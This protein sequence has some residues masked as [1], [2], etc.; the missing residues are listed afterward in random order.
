MFTNQLNDHRSSTS[1]RP[2]RPLLYLQLPNSYPQH[3]IYQTDHHRCRAFMWRVS[4][5]EARCQSPWSE[6]RAIQHHRWRCRFRCEG[7]QGRQQYSGPDILRGEVACIYLASQIRSWTARQSP[8][9][10]DASHT[11]SEPTAN[12]KCNMLQNPPADQYNRWDRL[13]IS[14]LAISPITR[15]NITRTIIR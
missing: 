2:C 5:S 11:W 14:V 15:V 7:R 13:E 1:H 9:T 3:T 6:F 4:S 12:R 10:I 8:L